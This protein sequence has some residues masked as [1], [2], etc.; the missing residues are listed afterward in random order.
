MD[1]NKTPATILQ[2]VS[3]PTGFLS[4]LAIWWL[5]TASFDIPLSVLPSPADAV[6][7]LLE[8]KGVFRSLGVTIQT[9][10][11]AL[12]VS[13]VAG[14]AIALLLHRWL[15]LEPLVLP[16][17]VTLQVTPVIVLAPVVVVVAPPGLTQ[18]IVAFLV[19]FF[20]ITVST[21]QG[22][23]STPSVLLDAMR[24]YP[25]SRWQ[26][27]CYLRWPFALPFF[28][29]GLRTAVGLAL[30]GAVIADMM[31][32]RGG[33]YSGI[34]M[35][36]QSALQGNIRLVFGEALLVTAVG[37]LLIEAVGMMSKL[38]LGQWRGNDG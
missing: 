36:I 28:F 19:A 6:I 3:L 25:V 27:F 37:I 24:I 5:I 30:V 23:K 15:L 14:V 12:L 35:R 4:L 29:S 1:A 32:G 11:I 33:Q 31:T 17:L 18:V 8:S 16:L 21:L 10:L 26:T 22:L 9:T 20:P 7:A 2:K 34:G 38:S 13:V